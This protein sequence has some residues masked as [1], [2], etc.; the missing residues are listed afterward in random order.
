MIGYRQV[1]PYSDDIPIS[2]QAF[3]YVVDGGPAGSGRDRF[4]AGPPLQDRDPDDCQLPANDPDSLTPL[5]RGEA[6]ISA[7]P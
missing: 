3:A 5:R 4:E 7:I 2:N 1:P 6:A